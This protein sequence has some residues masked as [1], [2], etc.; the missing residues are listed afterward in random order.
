MSQLPH[1]SEHVRPKYIWPWFVLAAFISGILLA[2]LWFWGEL[3]KVQRIR[4]STRE[5]AYSA[6]PSATSRPKAVSIS[7]TN[8]MVWIPGGSFSMGAEDGQP[9]EKP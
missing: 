2:A 4:E 7:W 9:D 1:P 3:R 6:L 5:G 8:G